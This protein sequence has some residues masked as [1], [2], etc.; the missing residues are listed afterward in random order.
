MDFILVGENT[1]NGYTSALSI[2]N[3]DPTV[4]FLQVNER[5]MI[6]KLLEV[7]HGFFVDG[8]GMTF[9]VLNDLSIVRN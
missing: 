3:Q 1:P 4:R 7:S 9:Q 8:S 2:Q 5:K 6:G